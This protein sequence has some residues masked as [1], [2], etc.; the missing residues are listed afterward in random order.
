MARKIVLLALVFSIFPV[1]ALAGDDPPVVSRQS[2]QA[3]RVLFAGDAE[4][5]LLWAPSPSAS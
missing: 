3:V 2:V 5:E 1:G 4:E